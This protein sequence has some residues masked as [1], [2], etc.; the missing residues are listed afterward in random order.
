M[1]EVQA[2]LLRD[3]VYVAGDSV[4]CL[5]TFINKRADANVD[6]RPENWYVVCFRCSTECRLVLVGRRYCQR[7]GMSRKP[8]GPFQPGAWN[9]SRLVSHTF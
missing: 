9:A 3:V 1:I 4:E 2:K 8:E 5:V 7:R 6:E